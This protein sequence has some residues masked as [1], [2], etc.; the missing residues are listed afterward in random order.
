MVGFISIDRIIT[1]VRA[2]S[3][4]DLAPVRSWGMARH[5]P[6]IALALITN[7]TIY[8]RTVDYD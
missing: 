8:P 1:D 4:A 2:G 6:H 5:V 3:G 7:R